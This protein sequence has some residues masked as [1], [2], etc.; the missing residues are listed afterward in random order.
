MRRRPA[1]PAFDLLRYLLPAATH[2][3][4]GLTLN[5]ALWSI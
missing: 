5:A 2:T 3:N 4:I 1:P